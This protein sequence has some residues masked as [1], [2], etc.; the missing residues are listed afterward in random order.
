[1][2]KLEKFKVTQ[3]ASE[4]REGLGSPF[5][6][7]TSVGINLLYKTTIDLSEAWAP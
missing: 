2:Y 3:E 4:T 7:P 1:V 6:E 5:K